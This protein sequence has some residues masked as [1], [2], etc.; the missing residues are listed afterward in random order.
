MESRRMGNATQ[1]KPMRRGQRVVR[2]TVLIAVLLVLP[3]GGAQSGPTGHIGGMPQPIGQSVGDSPLGGV[4]SGNNG[5]PDQA[6]RI[7]LLNAERQKSLVADTVKLLKLASELN[8]VM[9]K[10]DAS[11][12]TQAEIRKLADIE[13]LARNV[14]EKM[15]V[16]VI[17][18]PIY[19]NQSMP[20]IP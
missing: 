16:T 19:R 11:A 10:E 18:T 13:K 4:N 8:A 17:G 12:P 14:K 15:K 3:L 9:E 1:R 6:R 2:A 5:D 20:P 7:R